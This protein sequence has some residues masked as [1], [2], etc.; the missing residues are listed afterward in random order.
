M[1]TV[2]SK[3]IKV[4]N[5]LGTWYVI[6][7]VY[8]NGEQYFLLEHETHGDDALWVAINN[9]GDL[10]MDDISDGSGELIKFLA[11]QMS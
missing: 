10:I 2:N 11:D 7:E 3:G 9:K 4:K 5:H 6:E 1:L 8:Y